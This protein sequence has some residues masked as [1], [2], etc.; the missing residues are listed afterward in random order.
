[1]QINVKAS[2]VHELE[3]II[4]LMCQYHSKW[5]TDVMQFLSKSQLHFCRNRIFT[6]KYICNL[7]KRKKTLNSQNTVQKEKQSR[8]FTFPDF[9]ID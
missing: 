4:L 6:P 1:M 7:K 2:C 3:G 5:T 9:K 8:G